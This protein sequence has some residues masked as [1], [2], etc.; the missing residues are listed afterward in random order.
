MSS[1][2]PI[3]TSS[4]H[5]VKKTTGASGI[6]FQESTAADNARQNDYTS[7]NSDETATRRADTMTGINPNPDK[8]YSH[9]VK[10][11]EPEPKIRFVKRDD[12]K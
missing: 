8:N 2:K 4:N 12:S 10:Y 11:S 1:S 9:H 5:V 3:E 7:Y 6:S